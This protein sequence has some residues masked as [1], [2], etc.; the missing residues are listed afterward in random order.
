MYINIEI[1]GIAMGSLCSPQTWPSQQPLL[2]M[3]YLVQYM[4]NISWMFLQRK[5]EEIISGSLD[6]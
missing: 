4:P 5:A 6:K 3:V 2:S 1:E